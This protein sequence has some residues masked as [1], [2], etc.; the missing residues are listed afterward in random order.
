M[1][2]HTINKRLLQTFV[3]VNSLTPDRLDYVLHKQSVE[4]LTKGETLFRI[5]EEDAR[6]V[7]LL[8]G[9]VQLRDAAGNERILSAGDLESWHPVDHAQPRRSTAVALTDVS[10]LRLDSFRLD[11]VLSWDQYAGYV[12]FDITS[13]QALSDDADWMVRL[14]QS[15]IFY[16]VPPANIRDIFRRLTLL[17]MTAGTA[18]LRKGDVAD[19][20]YFIKS[21]KVGIF[22]SIEWQQQRPVAE[23]EPGQYFGEEGILSD[24][25]RNATVVMLTDG[26]LM[27]LEKSDFDALLRAPVVNEVD[28]TAALARISDGGQWLDVRLSDEIETGYLDDAI[29]IPLPGLRGK[30]KR[31][32][33]ERPVVV[34]CDT[35]RRSAAAAFLLANQG[36]HVEVLCGGLNGL[37]E[38]ELLGHLHGA[39]AL[40]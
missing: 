32:A 28:F 16:S 34:Y 8:S 35:G 27:R 38:A 36:Y 33:L 25:E 21:G 9:E 13:D 29:R 39:Q 5:G 1:A 2:F 26:E 10:V 7:Y 24:Q 31:L 37:S 3:P 40:L 6:T 4:S 11:T 19:C 17:P 18:V 23:L 20:C 30:L 15:N 22:P 14:L 12:L